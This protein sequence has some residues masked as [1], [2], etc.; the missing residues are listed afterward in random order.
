[1][2]QIIV[3]SSIATTIII[4]IIMIKYVQDVVIW[5]K[6]IKQHDKMSFGK[7]VI[8]IQALTGWPKTLSHCQEASVNRIRNRHCG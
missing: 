5:V 2:R 1:M 8:R 3:S 6:N 4:I 7:F